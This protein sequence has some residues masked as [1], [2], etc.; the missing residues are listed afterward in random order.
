M[1]KNQRQRGI[2]R[3]L[4]F[5]P[6]APRPAAA[7]AAPPQRSALSLTAPRQKRRRSSCSWRCAQPERGGG[8]QAGAA[9]RGGAE[10][11]RRRTP[12]ATRTAAAAV[13][14][15]A[16][17][18]PP[19]ARCPT[20]CSPN[21]ARLSGRRACCVHVLVAPHADARP[22]ADEPRCS[23][24]A[25]WPAPSEALAIASKPLVDGRAV[26]R[27]SAR[28][29][30]SNR[31]RCKRIS[32]CGRR[33]RAAQRVLE[34]VL[35]CPSRRRSAR[36]NFTL[37]RPTADCCRPISRRAACA[38][39]TVHLARP[40]GCSELNDGLAS[41]SRRYRCGS[42]AGQKPTANRGRPS[43]TSQ[44]L[45][46]TRCDRRF[47]EVNSRLAERDEYAVNLI[48]PS[49]GSC[50]ASRSLAQGMVTPG[51]RPAPHS[52]DGSDGR[53]HVP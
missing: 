46:P 21:C 49:A 1:G 44:A 8:A 42:A 31:C 32:Y 34:K 38:L 43:G 3:A 36:S 52:R 2:A 24:S 33:P 39:P 14:G 20:S 9:G 30:S 7:S 27:S 37:L 28:C 13:A 6:P 53:P 19:G 48:P 25:S 26:L 11:P 18:A 23:S 16:A 41:R 17:D 35:R 50:C 47:L 40:G 10:R 4:L 15:A 45:E 12:S 22:A 51:A 29:R 5:E